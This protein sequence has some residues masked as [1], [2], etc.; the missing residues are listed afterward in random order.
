MINQRGL[1]S[2]I[3]TFFDEKS[4]SGG[5]VKN[6]MTSNQETNRVITKINYQYTKSAF[7]F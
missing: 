2:I 4:A 1:A 3:Y 7:I 5:D 6:E